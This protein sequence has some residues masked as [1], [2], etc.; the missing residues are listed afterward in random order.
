MR[1]SIKGKIKIVVDGHR[2]ALDK[3]DFV[4]PSGHA[5]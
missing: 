3:L 4:R 1:T 5:D 2:A